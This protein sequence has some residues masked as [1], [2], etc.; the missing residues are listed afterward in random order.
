MSKLLKKE[1][2]PLK[3]DTSF[4]NIHCFIRTKSKQ[5]HADSEHPARAHRNKKKNKNE[6]QQSPEFQD[7]AFLESVVCKILNDADC[8]G[9]N[10]LID[11]MVF[12]SSSSA[13]SDPARDS[14]KEDLELQDFSQIFSNFSPYPKPQSPSRQSGMPYYAYRILTPAQY[15]LRHSGTRSSRR[16]RSER[17]RS[18]RVSTL[19]RGVPGRAIPTPSCRC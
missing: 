18:T 9:I 11:N 17:P 8:Q 1:H 10:E 3:F 2:S 7:K 5:K 6:H 4:A 13:E 12:P 16:S 14:R 19:S 15:P